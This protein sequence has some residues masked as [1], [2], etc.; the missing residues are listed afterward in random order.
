MRKII[1]L[2]LVLGIAMVLHGCGFNDASDRRVSEVDYTVVEDDKVPEELLK[3]IEDK[4]DKELRMTYA[5]KEYTYIVAGYGTCNTSGYSIR[6]DDLYASENAIVVKTTLLGPAKDEN[7][8]EV[9][10]TP[11]VV[12]KIERSEYPVI[13]YQM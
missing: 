4:K 5:T 2:A 6:V 3:L 10:T 11:Y 12:I 8:N 1:K 13:F 7:I 9:A